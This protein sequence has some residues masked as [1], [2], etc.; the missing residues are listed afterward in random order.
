MSSVQ[1]LAEAVITKEQQEANLQVVQDIMKFYSEATKRGDQ[2]F[3]TS[4]N[5]ALAD[6]GGSTSGQSAAVCKEVLFGVPMV[7]CSMS[8]F[9]FGGAE[10]PA[11]ERDHLIA[12]NGTP[13]MQSPEA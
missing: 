9:D 7:R 13:Q 3:W 12:M 4:F 6:H 8:S 5:N 1:A 2:Y 10:L 11:Q